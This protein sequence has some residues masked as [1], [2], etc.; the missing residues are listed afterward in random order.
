[1][2]KSFNVLLSEILSKNIEITGR[3]GKLAYEISEDDYSI[4][5]LK[6]IKKYK[7][8][9][10]EQFCPLMEKTN[11]LTFNESGSNTP[12]FFVHGDKAN[13]ILKNL[14]GNDQPLYGFLHLGSDGEKV[15]IKDIRT[16]AQVYLKHLLKIRPKGPYILGGLSI[17][18]NI[19]YEMSALLQEMGHEVPKLILFDCKNL[20]VK[21]PFNWNRTLYTIV[22]NSFVKPIYYRIHSFYVKVKCFPYRLVQKPIPVNLRRNYIFTIYFKMM[23]KYIGSG[24]KYKG[25]ILLIRA[26]KNDSTLCSLGWDDIDPHLTLKMVRGDHHD[27]FEFNESIEIIKRNVK[28]FIEN[29]KYEKTIDE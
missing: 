20:A 27:F 9:L 29:N 14:F 6:A 7:Y 15:P 21:E 23:R 4:E 25:D 22:R 18:G 26:E 1:M 16:L 3:N 28:V 11:I 8:E 5:L 19:A 10:L 13:Y 17:G 2:I 12:I 24:S